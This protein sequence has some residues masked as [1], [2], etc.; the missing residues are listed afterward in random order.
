MA[1]HYL[2]N[3]A[4][5]VTS[6]KAAKMA[7]EMMTVEYGNPSSL[8]KKG[9]SA[10][11]KLDKAYKAIAS[12]LS[13]EEDELYF[14]SGSTESNNTVIFGVTQAKKRSGKKIVTTAI[15]HSSVLEACKKLENDGFTVVY[16]YPDKDG[17]VPPSAFEE[18]VDSDTILVSVMAVNNEIG[19]IENIER[20]GKIVKRKNPDAHFHCDAVQAYGKMVLK[21]KK[22]NVDSLCVSAHKVHGPKGVGALYIKKGARITPLLYGGEQQRKVRPG[23]QCAP[24]IASF[25]VAVE[26]FDIIA[27]REHVLALNTYL[28]DEL[29][30]IDGVTINSSDNALPYVLNISAEGI[31]S[32]TMLHHL[33]QSD[34]YV[35]SSSACAK[36]KKSYVLK[37]LGLSDKLIDSSLRISFSKYNDKADVDAFLES[38]KRGID[39][40]AKIK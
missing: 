40:L 7:L 15:E 37:A 11:L 27:N 5:T 8:H 19:S 23:T 34:V 4:T 35:S 24:L 28:K 20:I 10:E 22:W 13:V 30:K 21:P 18:A 33:E 39:T 38:L 1:E 12:S 9:L 29:K 17:V 6:E 26:E 14:T 2:D 31:K 32:E 25:G 16:L 3:S 36:G